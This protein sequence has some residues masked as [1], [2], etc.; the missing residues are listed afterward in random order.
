MPSNASQGSVDLN[1]VDKWGVFGTPLDGARRAGHL[2]VAT[3]LSTRG[4]RGALGLHAAGGGSSLRASVSSVTTGWRGSS[5]SE[6]F[7]CTRLSSMGSDAHGS[8]EHISLVSLPPR[9][10]RDLL[11]PS[12]LRISRS[13]R[14]MAREMLD[15][16]S[17]WPEIEPQHM[18]RDEQKPAKELRWLASLSGWRFA[19]PAYHVHTRRSHPTFTPRP[20]PVTGRS[21]DV[22]SLEEASHG[23]ALYLTAMEV[24]AHVH[25]H[26][27]VHVLEEASHGHALYLT[28]MKVHAHVHVGAQERSMGTTLCLTAPAGIEPVSLHS[29][30]VYLLPVHACTRPGLR[31]P[32]A[33]PKLPHRPCHLW[34]LPAAGGARLRS[35]PVPQLNACGRRTDEH[36]PL[37]DQVRAGDAAHTPGTPRCPTGRHRA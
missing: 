24:H 21:F 5:A 11:E 34:P 33:A 6:S 28:A 36:A 23:H 16:W 18:S 9:P 3:F 27:H 19:P 8:G 15:S 10:P 13:A 29:Y 1:G 25:V 30:P 32:R 12:R 35:Q 26:V 22:I 14:R 2:A 31:S 7:Y 4:G 17:R 20:L 37:P